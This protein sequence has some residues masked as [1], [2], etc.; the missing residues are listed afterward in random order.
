METK[1][2][3]LIFIL[4]FYTLVGLFYAGYGDLINDETALQYQGVTQQEEKAGFFK[5]SFADTTG[6]DTT[7][8]LRDAITGMKEVP[9]WINALL[10]V[11]FLA[12]IYLLLPTY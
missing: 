9:A 4:T 12:L 5:K 6:L 11:I 1:V 2:G 3:V 10:G 8:F 7:G